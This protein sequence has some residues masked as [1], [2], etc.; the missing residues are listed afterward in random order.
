MSQDT[1]SFSESVGD[2]LRRVTE[3]DEEG[4]VVMNTGLA[5]RTQ[6]VFIR[7]LLETTAPVEFVVYS[8]IAEEE[9]MNPKVLVRLGA[10][11]PGLCFCHLEGYAVAYGR[12]TVEA[13]T[14]QT[15]RLVRYVGQVADRLEFDVARGEDVY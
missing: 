1:M 10:E 15:S 11:Y 4:C 7:R 8:R 3:R 6:A 13:T 9:V 2:V 14:S 12:L 5:T